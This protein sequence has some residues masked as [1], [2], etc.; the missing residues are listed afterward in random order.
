MRSRASA[1]P[2]PPK[3]SASGSRPPT[4]KAWA[5]GAP[6]PTRP[7]CHHHTRKGQDKGKGRARGTKDHTGKRARKGPK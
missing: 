6:S 1:P 7:S 4:P 5:T 3:P 2:T